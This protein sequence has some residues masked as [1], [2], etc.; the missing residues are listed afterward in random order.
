[1]LKKK[2]PGSLESKPEVSN[3]NKHARACDFHLKSET[4]G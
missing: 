3:M 1:M 2:L 4:E